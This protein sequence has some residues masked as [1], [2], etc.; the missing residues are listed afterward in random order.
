MT[1]LDSQI[2]LIINYCS[3]TSRM[4]YNPGANTSALRCITPTATGLAAAG[5]VGTAIVYEFARETSVYK[6]AGII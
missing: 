1:E 5:S 6:L 3:L 2:K 4:L